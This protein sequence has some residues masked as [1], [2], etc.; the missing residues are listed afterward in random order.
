[1]TV[2]AFR[3]S[4]RWSIFYGAD[5]VADTVASFSS[6]G[7]RMDGLLDPDVI[8]PGERIFSSLPLW[9]TVLD[10]DPYEYYGIWDGTSMATPHVS[11]AVAL[12][13]SYAKQHNLTYNP[14]MIK[15][16]LEM[17]AVP[18]QEATPVDQGFGLIHVD[19]AIAVLQNLSAEKTT[20]IYG[21]TTFTGFRNDLEEKEIPISPDYIEYNSYF[22]GLYDMPYLYRGVYIRNEFPA[23]VPLYFYPME[24]ENG[25]GLSP[26]AVEKAYHI[27]TSDD[28]IIPNVDTVIAG[29]ETFGSFSI[30]I[31]YSKL[32]PGHIYVGFVY[33]DDP[34]TSYID[35]FIPVI[36]D[37]PMNMNGQNKASLSDTALP[38][39]AKHYFYQVA[40]GTKEL[41]VTLRVPLD[42]NGTPMGRTTL[43]IAR[44]EG[45][46]VAEY[47]P[48][49]YFVGP[50]LPE[51][52]WVIKNPEPGTWEITAYTCTFTKPRTGYNESHYTISVETVGVTIQPEKIITDMDSPG[53]IHSAITVKNT[54]YGTFQAEL[55]GLGMGRLDQVYGMIRNVSQDDFDVIGAIP[56]TESDYYFRVGITQ[57]EDP[58]ADLD[59]YVYYFPTYEDLMNFTNYTVY[60]DQ[61][62]PTSDEVF[63]KFM[64]EP[65]YYLI[66]VYGYDTVGYDPIHYI[67]YYQILGDNGNIK[68]SPSTA[69]VVNNS[70]TYASVKINVNESGTYLGVIGVKDSSTGEVLDYAPVVVQAGLPKMVV[71]A[72]AEGQVVTGEPTKIKVLL[73]DAQNMTPVI[74]ESKVIVNDQIYYTNDGILE[75][76]YTPRG[77]HDT[78][79]IGVINPNYQD[80]EKT[81]TLSQ[82]DVMSK[83]QYWE[84][85]YN[86]ETQLYE[87]LTALV[88]SAIPEPIRTMILNLA[89]R[90]HNRAAYY[91]KLAYIFEKKANKILQMFLER[92]G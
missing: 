62:G 78:L 25:L 79:R 86:E 19:S 18:V 59:L 20:Y 5:G 74:G 80:V 50:G 76:Y 24:Y 58:N 4:Q 70:I 40:P 26:V 68:V 27:S 91:M 64:P 42:E 11:G 8:A 53:I 63:E 44:P 29:G 77:P 17:S 46:V 51:Y 38:G 36:V 45:A 28:W 92:F 71:M 31:D 22:Y 10:Q 33:I 75:F 12:L 81:F 7:P 30:Q 39:V 47:V 9:Y 57:P 67:F 23:G 6:R 55:Y 21:G 37:L 90:Y 72:Y 3:S 85:L 73:L 84:N 2:G 34:E 41:R 14:I 1:M 48:G 83:Y 65:G 61:I 82:I 87:N 69:P 54:N 49:Y 13:I 60:T 43:M 35:G 89:S 88:Q 16:A 32:Q 52:T 15:R 56:I 66:A